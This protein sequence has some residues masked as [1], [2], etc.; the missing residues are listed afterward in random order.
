M[1]LGAFTVAVPAPVEK[2]P[3][4]VPGEGLPSLASLNI[5]SEE[6]YTL[7]IPEHG[8]HPQFIL[9]S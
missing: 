5:T 1:L 4:I 2:Y 8:T 7:D 3:E 9:H 6:L